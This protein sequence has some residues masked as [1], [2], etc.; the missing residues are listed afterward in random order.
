MEAT[1]KSQDG[2]GRVQR[3]NL[4]LA[5]ES[6]NPLGF[7]WNALVSSGPYG[8]I[9]A[10]PPWHFAV[11]S[12]KG[13]DRS[14]VNHYRTMTLQDIAAMP[15]GDLAAKDCALFLWAI[16]PLLPEALGVLRGWGFRFATVGFYWAKTNRKSDG[17]FTGLG[18]Y[19]RA[20]PEQVLLGVKGHPHRMAKDVSRLVIAPRGEHS[21]K[22]EAVQDGIE[23]LMPGPYVELFARRQRSGWTCW[24]AE[25]PYVG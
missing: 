8:V 5:D 1:G 18:Y 24:G 19:T 10:D 13:E 20:N 6:V 12:E 2:E 23:R 11:R 15:V 7:G 14:A 22:P 25:C 9:C 4:Q 16:D 21:S 17:Y 3:G